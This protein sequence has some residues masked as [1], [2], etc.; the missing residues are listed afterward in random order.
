MKKVVSDIIGRD[1]EIN[2]LFTL[3]EESSIVISSTRRMGK[4]MILTKMHET[5]RADAKTMLCFVE[6]VQS[7]EEFVSVL[8]V[9]L[10]DQGLLEA[11]NFTKVLDWMNTNLGKKDIGFFKTP[12]FS[13]HWKVVLNLMMEDLVD[14][15]EEQ[16]ILMLDE[17]PKMLWTMAQNGNHQQAEE[18][19]DELRQIREH[20]EK[21]SGLRFIYCGSIGMNQV[22]NHLVKQYKYAGAPL[23]NMEHYIV[24]EMSLEDANQLVKHLVDKHN[25]GVDEVLVTYLAQACS[26]LPFFIDRIFTQLR[27][28]PNIESLTQ[29]DIDTTIEEFIS[30]R[31]NNN[32]FNHFTERIDA[33]YDKKEKLIAHEL[34]LALCKSDEP[35]T[36]EILLN[37]VKSKIEVEDF[38]IS[39]ILSDL[40]REMYVDRIT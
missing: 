24:E 19:L 6:S 16:I 18:V 7:A 38:E 5:T 15:Q 33:Y 28:S 2:E 17:F 14:N 11:K 22:I 29:R 8:R 34:L 32:Q 13:R 1:R 31:K 4:T 27:L 20:H 26:C 30:G 36:S 21:R 23:N 9:N 25:V 40:Y 39:E 35:L 10:I 12:D 3:L 37:I